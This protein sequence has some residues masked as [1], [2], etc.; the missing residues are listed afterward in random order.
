M[1]SIRSKKHSLVSIEAEKFGLSCNDTKRYIIPS[2]ENAFI[3]TLAFGHKDIKEYEAEA[4]PPLPPEIEDFT[5][6]SSPKKKRK[7]R[8]IN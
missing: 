4:P 1:H 7:K 6:P 5:P 8:N 3:R 2:G